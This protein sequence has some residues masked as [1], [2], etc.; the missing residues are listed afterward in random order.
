MDRGTVRA[1]VVVQ[2]VEVV[3]VD[4]DSLVACEINAFVRNGCK[5]FLLAI[6]LKYKM[7]T[8]QKSRFYR[9]KIPASLGGVLFLFLNERFNFL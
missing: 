5:Y 6:W 9:V 4:N 7:L 3:K 1:K 8:G 2:V